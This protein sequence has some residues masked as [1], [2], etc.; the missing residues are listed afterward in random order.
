MVLFNGRVLIFILEI[1]LCVCGFPICSPAGPPPVLDLRTIMDMEANSLQSLT[2]KSPGRYE[3]SLRCEM[4]HWLLLPS[5][6]ET[7]FC[8]I[9]SMKHHPGPTKLSQK[10]RKFL[11]MA[12]KEASVESNISKPTQPVTPSKSSGKAW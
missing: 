6:A 12:N 2:P 8:V 9:T 11:A 7:F 5:W 10:Q 1:H 3:M 4:D